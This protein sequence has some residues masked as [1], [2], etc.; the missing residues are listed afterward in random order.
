M[1]DNSTKDWDK[2]A[3]DVFSVFSPGLLSTFNSLYMGQPHSKGPDL[4]TPASHP[5]WQIGESIIYAK[6]EKTAIKYA[7]KRGL[8]KPEVTVKLL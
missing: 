1:K 5:A 7:K 2:A 4:K 8:W 6:D 3:R